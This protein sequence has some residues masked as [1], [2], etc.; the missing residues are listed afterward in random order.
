M[1]V[2][3]KPCDDMDDE[4]CAELSRSLDESMAQ[5]EA[6]DVVDGREFLA[7]LRAAAAR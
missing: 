5:V 2:E 4:E 1:G 7:S 6:G 3:L